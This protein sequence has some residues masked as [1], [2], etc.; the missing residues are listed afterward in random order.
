MIIGKTRFSKKALKE[1]KR[2]RE[3]RELGFKLYADEKL[4]EQLKNKK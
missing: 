3:I 1:L 4:K 2:R